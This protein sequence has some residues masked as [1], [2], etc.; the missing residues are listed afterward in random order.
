MGARPRSITPSMSN[1]IPKEALQPTKFLMY[2]KFF[3]R[4]TRNSVYS[5]DNR[6]TLSK[7]KIESMSGVEESRMYRSW[8]W[9]WWH[10]WS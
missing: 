2:K 8:R 4:M 3:K 6:N 10:D 1:A 5:E 7:E 9:P